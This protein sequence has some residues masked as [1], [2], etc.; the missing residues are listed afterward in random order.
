MSLRRG[1][2]LDKPR[3]SRTAI[4]VQPKPDG[5]RNRGANLGDDIVAEPLRYSEQLRRDLARALDGDRLATEELAA[6][7]YAAPERRRTPPSRS[8]RPP[9]NR[10]VGLGQD[11]RD[12]DGPPA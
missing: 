5:E 11:D 1:G 12:H 4:M 10:R 3:R 9:S 2:R 7:A 8:S 6:K